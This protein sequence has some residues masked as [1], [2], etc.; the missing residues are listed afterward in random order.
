M[1]NYEHK[2]FHSFNW[3]HPGIPVNRINTEIYR[4]RSFRKMVY[5]CYTSNISNLYLALPRSIF[6]FFAAKR[7]GEGLGGE[8]YLNK[9]EPQNIY[10][11]C[12]PSAFP[13]QGY[14]KQPPRK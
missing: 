12:F 6:A 3:L 8:M 5:E 2:I 10:N 9:W 1:N 7:V 14:L 13:V 11:I 4:Q